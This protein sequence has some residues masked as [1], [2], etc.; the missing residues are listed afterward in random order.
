MAETTFKEGTPNGVKLEVT[1]LID[2]DI[3]AELQAQGYTEKDIVEGIKKSITFHNTVGG[4]LPRVPLL[5]IM[6]VDLLKYY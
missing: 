4:V 3:W 1:A 2:K 6:G 5:D